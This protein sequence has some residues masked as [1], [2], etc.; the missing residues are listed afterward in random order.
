ML[1]VERHHHKGND[2]VIA[3]CK[4]SI[5]ADTPLTVEEKMWEQF[6]KMWT[7]DATNNAF[8]GYDKKEWVKL[9]ATILAALKEAKEKRV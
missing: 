2:L 9:E 6:H 4:T 1:Q 5:G 8:T 3:L 7:L